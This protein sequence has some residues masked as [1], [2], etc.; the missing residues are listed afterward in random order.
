[1]TRALEPSMLVGHFFSD[2]GESDVPDEPQMGDL[3]PTDEVNEDTS[4][5]DPSPVEEGLLPE[6]AAAREKKK[7]KKKEGK[8][9]KTGSTR[10]VE[11]MFRTSYRTHLDLSTLAD[12]KANIMISIN[13][14]IISI[15][16]ASIYPRIVDNRLLLLP[17]AVLLVFCLLSLVYAV[18]AARPRV[19]RREATLEDVRQD[20]ANILFFGTFTTMKEEDFLQ[21]MRELIQDPERAY[22]N[23]IRDIYGLGSVLEKKYR[24]LRTSYTVFM[25]GLIL[26]V[27]LFLAAFTWASG[28]LVGI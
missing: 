1:M 25:V 2:K 28:Y 20:K 5:N 12:N 17:T 22:G 13:G 10:G 27:V 26:G 4:T 11:T 19:T 8:K 15:L 3:P 23:M 24:L 21:G 9:E 16:L 6:A 18:L 7:G 14:I